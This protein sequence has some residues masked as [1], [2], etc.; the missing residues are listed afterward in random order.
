MKSYQFPALYVSWTE[1]LLGGRVVP[2]EPRATCSDCPMCKTP[3]PVTAQDRVFHPSAKCCTYIPILPNFLVGGILSD[4][5]P[6]FAEGKALFQNQGEA[7]MVTPAG[8]Q[9]PWYYWWHYVDKNFGETEHL[10]CPYYINRE[11]GLCG[12]WQYRN[13]RCSTWFCK[14]DRGIFGL[15]F[16]ATLSDLLACM[17]KKLSD[18]C[19]RELDLQISE[20]ETRPREA[21]WGNWSGREQDF[22]KQCFQSVSAL[23]WPEAL[24]LSGPEGLAL[25]EDT[26]KKFEMLLNPPSVPAH[27][28]TGKFTS[29]DLGNEAVRVWGYRSFDPIDHPVQVF[30]Q[31]RNGD[32][33]SLEPSMVHQLYEQ[34]ILVSAGETPTDESRILK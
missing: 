19:V 9:P 16:W 6:Q 15:N 5:D 32:W 30:E 8:V 17:E 25:A 23:T 3:E 24:E 22:Y 13:S 2:D 31:I 7:L 14:H 12:I 18:W 29:E 34:Q 1:Q 21:V 11:G 20:Q 33:D 4:E 27:L 26:L 10:R 28:Q